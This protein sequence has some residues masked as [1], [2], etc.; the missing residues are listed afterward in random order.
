MWIFL[1]SSTVSAQTLSG[2]VTWTDWTT[3]TPT[4]VQ[5]TIGDVAVSFSGQL[6]PAP[7]L[8]APGDVAYW[9]TSAATYTGLQVANSP[10]NNDMIR[11]TGGPTSGTQ[12]VTFSRPVTNPVMTILSLGGGN[13]TATM[14][15]G[16]QP[17]VILK[18]GTGHFGTGTLT[19]TGNV[20]SGKEGNG[21]IQFIGTVT[22]I[23]WTTPILESWAA[24][25]IG[26]D[27]GLPPPDPKSPPPGRSIAVL[28]VGTGQ[29]LVTT[30]VGGVS[31]GIAPNPVVCLSTFRVQVGTTVTIS[32]SAAGGSVFRGW[33]GLPQACATTVCTFTMPR[34]HVQVKAMFNLTTNNPLD[35]TPPTAPV[36]SGTVL[37]N[38]AVLLR[39]TN[40]T[41]NN[42]VASFQVERCQGV[43]CTNFVASPI[44]TT[45]ERYENTLSPSTTY[46]Y[47]VKAIDSSNLSS[48]YSPIVSLTTTG[49]LAALNWTMSPTS[50]A[51]TRIQTGED[52]VAAFLITNT[53]PIGITVE[54]SQSADWL[55]L[56]SPTQYELKLAPGATE[57]FTAVISTKAPWTCARG[58]PLAPGVY[59]TTVS[60]KTSIGVTRTLPVTLTV[61][62]AGDFL[63]STLNA[64]TFS[65]FTG[66][67]DPAPQSVVITN[68]GPGSPPLPLTITNTAPWLTVTP[69]GTTPQTLTFTAT[70]GSVVGPVSLSTQVVISSPTATNPSNSIQIPVVMNILASQM[71][72][73]VATI[74][75]TVEL[76]DLVPIPTPLTITSTGEPIVWTATKPAT[77]TW[78]SLSSMT[79]TTGTPI[80]V[81]IDRTGLPVTAGTLTGVVTFTSPGAISKT[82]TVTVFVNPA[83]GVGTLTWEH[84]GGDTTATP[85]IPAPVTFR[86]YRS[87]VAPAN[88]G[89]LLAI[90]PYVAGQTT[91]TYVDTT[92]FVGTTYFFSVTA[93]DEIGF[94]SLPSNEV[95]KLY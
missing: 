7:Q 46:N 85:P 31:C 4:T 37:N 68:S 11:F 35:T 72:L 1:L 53:S 36:L 2:K 61:T 15:F 82:L 95:S 57:T 89:A 69:G 54:W 45:L 43:G 14:D 65:K 55:K 51:V 80:T 27:M 30:S 18:S 39:W 33:V 50:Y 58:C 66:G 92:G 56:I 24:F 91:Y 64:L 94:E 26:V 90:V 9:N 25:T 41:D 17:F 81:T 12:T 63:A 19:R 20:L 87:T 32:A 42:G 47:R 34:T 60:L 79:G 40:V 62:P 86:I 23:T 6:L 16:P 74:S 3:A 73:S 83:R 22:S 8:G 28:K 21:L 93:V 49:K 67:T 71:T 75:K 10:S 77:M 48:A 44:Q 70:Q 5:G 52:V 29:G 38:T 59:S 88:R 76:N 78:L 84:P 13:I